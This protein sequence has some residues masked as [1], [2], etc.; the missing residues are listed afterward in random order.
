VIAPHVLEAIEELKAC[1]FGLE[2]L[3]EPDGSGG[4]RVLLEHVPLGGIYKPQ[5]TWLGGHLTVQIPYADVYPLFVRG[6]LSRIDG[7]PLGDAIAPGHAFMNRSAVQ[8]S[9]RSNGRDPKIETPAIKF[10]KVI[11]WIRNRP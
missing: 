8:V 5:D 4:A 10:L 7:R 2:A 1:F 3:T 11:E 9:R 6:D